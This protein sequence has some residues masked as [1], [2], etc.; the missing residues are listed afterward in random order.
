MISLT[1]AL[2]MALAIS[3]FGVGAAHAD[4]GT[5]TEH[6]LV[7]REAAQSRPSA[8]LSDA[9]TKMVEQIYGYH[10]TYGVPKTPSWSSSPQLPQYATSAPIPLTRDLVGNAGAQDDLA[11]AIHHPGSGTGW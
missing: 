9:Q 2:A 11:R 7:I 1:R 10:G 6:D 5:T 8:P 3:A 4:Y